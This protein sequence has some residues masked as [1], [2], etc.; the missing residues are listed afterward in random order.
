VRAELLR[1]PLRILLSYIRLDDPTVY[2]RRNPRAKGDHKRVDG[3]ESPYDFTSPARL[4]A[5]F[6]DD[7]DLWRP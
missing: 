2:A 1:R 3:V 4:L 6:W 5:D 7:V